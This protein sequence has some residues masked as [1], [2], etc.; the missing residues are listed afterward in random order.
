MTID[1]LRRDH[2]AWTRCLLFL[3]IIRP[4]AGKSIQYKTNR[5]MDWEDGVFALFRSGEEHCIIGT[6]KARKRESTETNAKVRKVA[7]EATGAETRP[8]L[9]FL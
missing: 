5:W 3:V 6:W 7:V 1:N 4:R 9:S 2:T 8:Y